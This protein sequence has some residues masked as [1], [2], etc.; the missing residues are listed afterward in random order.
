[1]T[2]GPVRRAGRVGAEGSVSNAKQNAKVIK[3]DQKGPREARE[4]T[5]EA[6]RSG[7]VKP[8][9]KNPNRDQARGDWDRT[10]DHHDEDVES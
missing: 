1:M 4:E 3:R 8:Q 2:A 7:A 5:D 10:G 6:I 9:Q